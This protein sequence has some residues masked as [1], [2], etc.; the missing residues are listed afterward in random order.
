[1][2]VLARRQGELVRIGD[3]IQ[4]VVVD[5]RGDTVRIG[6]AAPDGTPIFREEVYQR[7]RNGEKLR[8][9]KLRGPVNCQL[10]VTAP[11]GE[12]ADVGP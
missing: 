7:I 12:P 3:D 4:V 2:L 8:N 11:A 6:F 5:I 1:M 10:D 9:E